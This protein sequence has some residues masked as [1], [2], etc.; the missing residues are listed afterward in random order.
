[1]HGLL[2]RLRGRMAACTSVVLVRPWLQYR[3]CRMC[4]V[5]LG[6]L[7]GAQSVSRGQEDRVGGERWLCF[8]V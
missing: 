1:M 2:T 4:P 8:D 6:Q 3:V 7:S 5:F